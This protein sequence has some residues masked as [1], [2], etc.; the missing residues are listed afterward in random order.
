LFVSPKF[1]VVFWSTIIFTIIT[2]SVY[3]INDIVDLPRDRLHPFK[4]RRPIASGKLPIPTAIFMAVV[5]FTVAFYLAYSQDFFFFLAVLS[6]FFLQM[7]YTFWLKHIIVI[8]VLAIAAG[9]VLRV[10]AG[11]FAI[12]VH[13]NV[14]FLLCLISL[15][16]F[17]AVGKRRAELA[18]L[19][20]KTAPRHRKT[21]TFYSPELL[22]TYLAMFA[23]S[24][25]LTYALFTFFFPPVAKSNRLSLLSSLPLTLIGINKWLMATIPLVIFGVMRYMSIIYQGSRAESPE[26]ILLSDKPLLIASFTWGVLVIAIIYGVG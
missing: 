25:W 22:D 2:S 23:N 5:G 16:L 13:M 24:A 3:L 17:L 15:S 14:W 20:E 26:R 8:D 18:I 12:N 19:T 4:K 21:L 10:Y 11:A 1:L 9:F 7:A 6:Y